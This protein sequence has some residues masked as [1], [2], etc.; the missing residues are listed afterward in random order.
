MKSSETH[1]HTSIRSN[2]HTQRKKLYSHIKKTIHTFED[3]VYLFSYEKNNS[4][5]LPYSLR[6]V[7][8]KDDKMTRTMR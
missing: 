7:S 3:I 8:V 1:T 5:I 4:K 6:T 2:T